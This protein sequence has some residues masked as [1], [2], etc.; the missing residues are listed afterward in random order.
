[1]FGDYFRGTTLFDKIT[2]VTTSLKTLRIFTIV[3]SMLNNAN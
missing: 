3:L 2:D 1:M